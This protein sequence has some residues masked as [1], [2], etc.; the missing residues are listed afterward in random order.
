[1]RENAV[2]AKGLVRRFDK[3]VAVAGLDLSIA[4]GEFYGLLGQNGAGKTTTIK[5]IVGLLRPDAGSAGV[6]GFNTWVDPLEVKKRIG[7]LPEE[8]NLYER[9]TGSELLDFT[10]AVHGV[11]R[12]DAH[13][14][15]DELLSVLD[16]DD[17]ANRLIGDYSR[18]MRKK[19][20]LAAA[21]IHAPAVLFLDEPLE[22]VDA[23][24]A[25]L[26]Q[27][28][29]LDY[30]AQGATVV[31]SSHVMEQVEK[32]CTR[33]G[34]MQRGKMVVEDTPSGL[35][36]QFGVATVEDAFLR[37]VGAPETEGGLE[38]LASSSG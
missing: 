33:I 8:F 32:L 21:I 36:A 19:V 20:A 26:I 5:M 9:L 11:P 35:C 30:T 27:R 23:V 37:A 34:I 22:G 1:M 2:W 18:G 14:R 3:T 12:L 38:W 31:F 13:R 10:A 15:R 17:A 28:L 7:V 4:P 6:F 29:L 24:S 25:R 16:L